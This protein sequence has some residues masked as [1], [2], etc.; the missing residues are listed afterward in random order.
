M[1]SKRY[2]L[3]EKAMSGNIHQSTIALS[4][5]RKQKDLATVAIKAKNGVIA[6]FAT[7]RVFSK[8]WLKKISSEARSVS[9]QS[10]AE[11]KLYGDKLSS[12]DM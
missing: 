3:I 5:I 1:T 4:N 11:M 6:G 12:Y 7:R 2:S 8:R 10:L 9:A